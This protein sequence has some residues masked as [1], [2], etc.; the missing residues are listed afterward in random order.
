MI[1]IELN[2]RLDHEVYSDFKNFKVAGVDFGEKI[3]EDHPE[4]NDGNYQKF[5]MSLF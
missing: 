4:I 3:K 1:T 2:S 5:L